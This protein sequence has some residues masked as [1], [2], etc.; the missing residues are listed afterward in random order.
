MN[1]VW[2][3]LIC[4]W[5]IEKMWWFAVE[6]LPSKPSPL[7]S[8]NAVSPKADTVPPSKLDLRSNTTIAVL[9]VACNRPDAIER[10]LNQLLKYV[11]W[12]SLLPYQAQLKKLKSWKYV[13]VQQLLVMNRYR[14][15]VEQFPIIVS[16]D[17]GHEETTNKIRSF[18]DRVTLIQVWTCAVVYCK[19]K[20]ILKRLVKK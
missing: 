20:C 3:W 2:N 1:L 8:G 5:I 10:S 15:S 6:P 9:V 11:L 18:G 7:L 4:Q 14:F 17:C 13:Y 16:Q 19:F 12:L